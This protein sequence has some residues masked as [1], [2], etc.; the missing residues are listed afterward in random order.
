MTLPEKA[1]A[2]PVKDHP[3]RRLKKGEPFTC[4]QVNLEEATNT[5]HRCGSALG[6][7]NDHQCSCGE[8]WP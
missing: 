3:L 2:R 6:H 8:S 7:T 4:G 5:R 1:K